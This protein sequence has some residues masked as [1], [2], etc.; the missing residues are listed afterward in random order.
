MVHNSANA[1]CWHFYPRL[2]LQLPKLMLQYTV[3]TLSAAACKLKR[4]YESDG[5]MSSAAY[6]TFYLLLHS[7]FQTS[8][9]EQYSL[10]YKC[11]ARLYTKYT[12]YTFYLLLYILYCIYYFKLH[13]VNNTVYDTKQYFIWSYA[14]CVRDTQPIPR[15]DIF[16]QVWFS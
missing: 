6:Y 15:L 16:D 2:L 12:Y 1:L 10:W 14:R 9:C 7:I 3:R 8:L 11:F 13:F 5:P 4:S